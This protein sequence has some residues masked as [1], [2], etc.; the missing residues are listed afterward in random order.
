[1]NRAAPPLDLLDTLV[2]LLID[3]NYEG[4]AALTQSDRL[5]AAE[6]RWALEQYGRTLTAI[7]DHGWTLA[8]AVAIANPREGQAWSV[9]LPLWTVEEG[10]SDLE[11]E[12]TICILPDGRQTIRLDNIRVP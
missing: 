7:P 9:S 4:A 5:P 2:A 6:M 10:R 11:V 12:T 3:G 1:M 8:D